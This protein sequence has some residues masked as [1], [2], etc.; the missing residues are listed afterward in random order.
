M[1]PETIKTGGYLISCVSV[2]LLGMSAY[3]GA[4]KAGLAPAL[5]AG[6]ATSIIGMGLRWL[7]YE[8]ERRQEKAAQGPQA[9]PSAA[10]DGRASAGVS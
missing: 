7:S 6:M 1:R 3:P 8:I 5:F 10:N 9:A 4:E 2:A